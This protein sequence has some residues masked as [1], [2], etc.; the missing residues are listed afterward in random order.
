[1]KINWQLLILKLQNSGIPL[2]TVNGALRRHKGWAH[3]IARGEIGE[4]KFSD[5]IALLDYAYD[6]LPIEVF[7]QCAQ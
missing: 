7:R 1:M 4:P 3:Q 2:A 6:H 5:A